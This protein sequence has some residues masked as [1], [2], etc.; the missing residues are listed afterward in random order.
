MIPIKAVYTVLLSVGLLL[1]AGFTILPPLYSFM[2]PLGAIL[3]GF[4]GLGIFLI[5]SFGAHVLDWAHG[6]IRYRRERRR[7]VPGN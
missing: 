2:P 3:D 4:V 6:E 1:A 7:S 5:A